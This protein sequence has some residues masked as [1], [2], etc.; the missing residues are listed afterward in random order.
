LVFVWNATLEVAPKEIEKEHKDSQI[1]HDRKKEVYV[2]MG[3]ESDIILLIL[4]SIGLIIIYFS[5][6][7]Q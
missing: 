5:F 7:N 1:G 2:G 3:K 4:V 6:F